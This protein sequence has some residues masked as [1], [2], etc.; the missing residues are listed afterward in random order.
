MLYKSHLEGSRK[1]L[2]WT[3][4]MEVVLVLMKIFTD[5]EDILRFISI[6]IQLLKL[7][8]VLYTL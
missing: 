2:N 3:I 8:S 5:G 6:A 1:L 7:K 4:K